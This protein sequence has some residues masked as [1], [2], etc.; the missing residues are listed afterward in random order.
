ME[1]EHNKEV[2]QV[3]GET[4]T[5]YIVL[6]RRVTRIENQHLTCT[7]VKEHWEDLRGDGLRKWRE[8]NGYGC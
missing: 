7:L 6:T 2:Y 3:H 1:E 8:L 5:G 4:K